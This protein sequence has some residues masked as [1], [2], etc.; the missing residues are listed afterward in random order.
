MKA[1]RDINHELLEG[2]DGKEKDGTILSIDFSNAFRSTSL[3]WFNLVMKQ[4][5]IPEEFINWFWAMYNNLQVKKK[6]MKAYQ[7]V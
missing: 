6:G 3:R 7:T 1:L 5:N 4:L 2:N